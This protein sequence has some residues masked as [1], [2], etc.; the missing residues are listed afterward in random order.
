MNIRGFNKTTLLDYPAHLAAT[1]FLGGCNFRCPYCHNMGLVLS[2]EDQPEISK[3]EILD[4]LKKRKNILE[5]ICITGGE[6]TLA[7]DLFDFISNIK[8]LG[9]KVKLD[10]NGYKPEVIGELIKNKLIDYI[11]MDIK[12]SPQGY[13]RVCQIPSLDINKIYESVRLIISSDIDYEFR[14]TLVKEL[15]DTDDIISISSWLK[16]VK[17]YY[18]QPFK[19]S[20]QVIYSGFSSFSEQE[21]SSFLAILSK[22]IPNVSVRG[23][24]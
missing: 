24:N 16:G 19:D 22:T 11:A 8:V 17:A 23:I 5:G 13:A 2:P 3:A 4:F 12:S 9:Y 7:A 18:L 1:V 21:L 10:T 14:T 15:H 20:G 6:P